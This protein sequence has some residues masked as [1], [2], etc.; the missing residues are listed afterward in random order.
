MVL[1]RFLDIMNSQDI[2]YKFG[3]QKKNILVRTFG[4][5]YTITFKK[6]GI[7]KTLKVLR[8]FHATHLSSVHLHVDL[9]RMCAM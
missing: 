9:L 5:N 3:F 6:Q 4:F 2:F 7:D 1:D 8:N